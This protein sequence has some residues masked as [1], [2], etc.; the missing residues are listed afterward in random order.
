MAMVGPS[1]DATRSEPV[2]RA[3]PSGF[4]PK[5]G[6]VPLG[7]GFS[8]VGAFSTELSSRSVESPSSTRR[9]IP[10]TGA[11]LA[12]SSSL[13]STKRLRCAGL[14]SS[15]SL[16]SPKRLEKRGL[17][18]G[19]VGFGLDDFPNPKRE[20]D[21]GRLESID[22]P[23]SDVRVAGLLE[24]EESRIDVRIVPPP[25]PTELNGR[26]AIDPAGDVVRAL[27]E[28]VR[29]VGS[30]AST[31]DGLIVRFIVYLTD[32]GAL[33]RSFLKLLEESLSFRRSMGF[34]ASAFLFG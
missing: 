2:A 13:E 8:S 9:G 34:F 22:D 18:F 24:F 19:F 5:V 28:V 14:L 4:V 17:G 11:K 29:F 3:K 15:S 1:P 23:R 27:T 25:G 10:R 16:E 32:E 26:R 6:F 7:F 20:G 21:F 33:E 31:D 12:G 30:R